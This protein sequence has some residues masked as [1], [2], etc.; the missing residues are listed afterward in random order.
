[1]LLPL[2]ITGSVSAAPIPSPFLGFVEMI[3]SLVPICIDLLITQ[4]LGHVFSVPFQ[5]YLLFS[6]LQVSVMD[7]LSLSQLRVLVPFTSQSQLSNHPSVFAF[8]SKL[9]EGAQVDFR[10]FS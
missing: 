5:T 8:Y 7:R 10:C 6:S 1:M 4:S 9:I 3:M 2:A